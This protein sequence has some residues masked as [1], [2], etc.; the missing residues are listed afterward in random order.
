MD[1]IVFFVDGKWLTKN[2]IVPQEY[3]AQR[4][5]WTLLA[6]RQYCLKQDEPGGLVPLGESASQL[7]I[8][9]PIFDPIAPTAEGGGSNRIER[10]SRS[11]FS[12]R[13]V[14]SPAGRAG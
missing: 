3:R 11:G 2:S 12:S 7:V 1:W 5:I 13:E 8:L 14:P 9:C 6:E 4:S 10:Y